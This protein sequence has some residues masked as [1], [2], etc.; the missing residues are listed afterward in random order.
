M[1][2]T[3]VNALSENAVCNI[4]RINSSSFW[5]TADVFASGLTINSLHEPFK[6]HLK[7]FANQVN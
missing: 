6:L 7:S 3:N 5:S 2:A 4:I 1:N